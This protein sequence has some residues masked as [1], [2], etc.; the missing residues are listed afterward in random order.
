MFPEACVELPETPMGSQGCA[1]AVAGRS[2]VL[3]QLEELEG[4]RSE[5]GL[6]ACLLFRR[7]SQQGGTRLGEHFCYSSLKN[8][9]LL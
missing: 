8:R 3:A 6:M 9:A 4:L 2:G 5:G 1:E 7:D